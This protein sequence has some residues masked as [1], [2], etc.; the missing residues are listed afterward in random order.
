MVFV[1]DKH[2]KPLM[3]CTEK[4]ARQMLQKGKA[5]AH[6][7]FPFTIRLKGRIVE[8]SKLQELRLK[9]DPGSKTTGL[10]ILCENAGTAKA[11]WFGEVK[12]K[13][14]VKDKLDR[15][16]AVRRGRRNRKTRY[17]IKRFSHR[18][19]PKGWLPPSLEARIQQTIN[20]VN[21]L[22]KSLP[23]TAISTEH[24]KFDTQLLQNPEISGVEYQQGE[25][26]GYEVREYLLEKF[27][28]RCAYCG[29][30]DVSLEVEHVVPKNP[31][32][33]LKGT[34]RISNLAIACR[35]CNEAK[36]NLQPNEWL[37]KLL[38]SKKEI[39]QTRA[40]NL[41][42]VLTRLKKPL[43]DAAMLNA[44][45][46]ALFKRLKA[47]GT[48]IECGTG[49]RT[50]KQRLERNLPKTHY[51]DAVCVGESTPEK[52]SISV[53]YV[54]VWS[55]VGRGSR[56]IANVDKYGF[57]KSY[58][59]RQKQ[60]FGFQTG[61]IVKAEVPKGKYAGIWVGRVA[62]R[63]TGYFDVKDS[64]GKRIAQGVSHKYMRVLQRADGWGYVAET[65]L[66]PH[67]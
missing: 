53:K 49:A 35:S 18:T 21:K 30:K 55:A 24:V 60:H 8:M 64:T 42:K 20:A 29:V 11:I 1:L 50:K 17:R 9:L 14:G 56:R 40:E 39:D 4:R 36:D 63:S 57:P 58:R 37:E 16:R 22:C 66:P 38:K 51:Y 61:D 46:W 33:G 19:R 62:V 52:I 32:H 23:I 47:T 25:L 31:I 6:K 28:R 59:V 5:V 34:D 26:L 44:T 54:D 45:R 10:A 27:G 48:P 7:L 43:K 2:K 12:H 67:I 15:R 13:P 3:P 65:A 41:P